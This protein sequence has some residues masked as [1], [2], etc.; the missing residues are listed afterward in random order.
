MQKPTEKHR[1]A[2]VLE[3]DDMQV[4]ILDVQ[5]SQDI[6]LVKKDKDR[7]GGFH[8]D[9]LSLNENIQCSVIQDDGGC[10]IWV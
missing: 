7:S 2:G 9:I 1:K 6:F 5:R 8:A 3:E 10:L 4:R